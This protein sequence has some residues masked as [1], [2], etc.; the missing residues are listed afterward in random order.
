MWL[1]LD[2]DLTMVE[3]KTYDLLE[4]L[5]DVGGLFDMLFLIGHSFIRPIGT[6]VMQL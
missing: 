3:R 1:E 4:W 2:S 6:L 5:G